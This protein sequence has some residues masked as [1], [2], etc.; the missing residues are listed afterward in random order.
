MT[1]YVNHGFVEM[2]AHNLGSRHGHFCRMLVCV[3]PDGVRV[4]LPLEKGAMLRASS[5]TE[6]PFTNMRQYTV[7]HTVLT[8]VGVYCTKV[9][10]KWNSEYW[11]DQGTVFCLTERGDAKLCLTG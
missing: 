5:K 8:D 6:K 3:T 1:L 10:L 9:E 2:V 11:E 4:W 7:D